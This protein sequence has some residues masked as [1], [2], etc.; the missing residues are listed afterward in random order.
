MKNEISNTTLHVGNFYVYT[1]EQISNVI[2]PDTF[3]QNVCT[4]LSNIHFENI[5]TFF[6]IKRTQKREG[7]STCTRERGEEVRKRKKKLG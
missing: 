6:R 7:R 2:P 3:M 1:S 4:C 5:S